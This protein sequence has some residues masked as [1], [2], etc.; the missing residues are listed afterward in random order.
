MKTP[1]LFTA[2]STTKH[3]T[4]Y[5]CGDLHITVIELITGNFCYMRHTGTAPAKDNIVTDTYASYYSPLPESEPLIAHWLMD[6]ITGRKTQNNLIGPV[7]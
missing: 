7:E 3:A 4:T 5:H 2:E 1:H 6:H